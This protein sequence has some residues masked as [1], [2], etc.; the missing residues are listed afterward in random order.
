M[1]ILK[2]LF[3]AGTSAKIIGT[4]IHHIDVVKTRFHPSDGK[5]G[6]GARNY[7]DLRIFWTVN[8]ILK[9][10]QIKSFWK[11]KGPSWLREAWY[12]SLRLGLYATIEHF[13]LYKKT[14]TSFLNLHLDLW[15][16]TNWSS[17]N[18]DYGL[19]IE[20]LS[21][22]CLWSRIF[23]DLQCGPTRQIWIRLMNHLCLLIVYIKLKTKIFMGKFRYNLGEIRAHY[24]RETCYLFANKHFN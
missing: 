11:G 10:E 8:V 24:Y 4:F 6:E 14:Q 16:V 17:K 1:E 19:R 15:H 22:L 23:Y 12:T 13:S 9:E 7:K 18:K 2:S 20:K 5:A 21:C 3:G